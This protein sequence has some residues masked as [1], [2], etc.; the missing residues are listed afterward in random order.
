MR[1]L[2]IGE[3]EVTRNEFVLESCTIGKFNLLTIIC[4]DDDCTPQNNVPSETNVSSN[5]QMIQF[6]QTR[7]R[8]ESFL[9]CRY[10]LERISEFDDGSRL[11]HSF[12]VHSELTVFELVQIRSDQEQVGARFDGEETRSRNVDTVSVLEVLDSGSNSGL[13][14]NNSFTLVGLFVV[15]DNFEIHSI[16][17]HNSLDSFQVDPQVVGVEDLE[18][19]NRFEILDVIRRDLSDFEESYTSL[20]VDQSSSL[21]ISLGLVSNFHQELSTRLVHVFQNV[22]ID[23]S[24]QVVNV[25]NEKVFFSLTQEFVDQS[26]VHDCI[27]QNSVTGRVPRGF[28][29]EC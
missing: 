2:V 10:F 13:E 25:G 19:S 14:L 6:Q 21:D 15:D 3:L 20:V 22:L 8:L 18:L 1:D 12:R 17:F 7:D 9:E 24:S 28:I 23:D 4:D 26:R 11:E 27:E 5:G 29:F 16:V